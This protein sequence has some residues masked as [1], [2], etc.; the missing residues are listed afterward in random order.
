MKILNKK[1][2]LLST[3]V[4]AISIFGF[5]FIAAK[6]VTGSEWNAGDIIDNTVFE[7]K[8]SMSV[9]QVQQFLDAKVPSCDAMGAEQYGSTDKTVYQYFHP[10]GYKFP[11]TCLK[12]YYENPTNNQNNLTQNDGQTAPIPSGAMSAAQI[13]VNAAQQYSINP[14]VLIVLLQK[15]SGLITDDSPLSVQYQSAT[16]Y[17]CPD[18]QS[19]NSQYAGF[20]NQLTNAAWQFRQY[21]TNPNA[22]SYVTGSGNHIQYNPNTSCGNSAVTIIN[23]ATAS[24]YNYTP[25]QPNQAAL[26]NLYGTGD[27]CSSYG[28]R[29]FWRDFND[30]FGSPTDS[31]SLSNQPSSLHSIQTVSSNGNLYVF[32]YDAYR[33]V[34]RL[35][36]F[37]TT[38]SYSILDGSSQAGGGRVDASLGSDVAVTQYGNSIQLFYYDA[39]NECLRHAWTDQSGNWHFENLDGGSHA[40]SGLSLPV[41]ESISATSY[42]G[43][44]QVFYY[45]QVHGVLRHAWTSSTA[46][47]KF[48][49]LDGD[50]G[51]ISGFNAKVGFMNAS[52][53]Y[54][55][56]LQVFYYDQTHGVLRHAWISSTAGWRFEDLDG[57]TGSI[58]GHGGD[59]GYS[60]ALTNYLGTNLQLF[61]Y[62]KTHGVLRHAWTSAT[63]GWRFE[64]LDGGTGSIAGHGG[65][66]GYSPTV[67]EYSTDNSLQ[68]YY[69]DNSRHALRHAWTSSTAGWRFED[70]D[71]TSSSVNKQVGNT[72]INSSVTSYDTTASLQLF[73]YDTN[74]GNLRHAWSD[75]SG[76]HF[77]NLG[78]TVIY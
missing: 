38:W 27:S 65:D 7:N 59:V 12:D 61:Y 78:P 33:S 44:L 45:D 2:M 43:T 74:S 16:G 72:G 18:Y 71:G 56:T 5:N 41:G 53:S 28:N 55:G 50:P 64:D 35:A 6:A 57:G 19:C 30:W 36:E 60:P 26:S 32:Y 14:E 3:L 11:V 39:T 48:E 22:F 4:V 31:N 73:Y 49:N 13:I 66:V 1:Y 20:Y 75:V 54:N 25:Y 8:N 70:L 51:S 63:S 46:G 21:A 77:E 58:A 24:L 23:Q 69:Y 9:A 29:N 47:W 62:D 67:T 76:W 15:E 68:L 10:K 52:T 42:N 34:L 17:G 37:T 40:V